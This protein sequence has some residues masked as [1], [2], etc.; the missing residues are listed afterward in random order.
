LIDNG[1]EIA[2]YL[3][4]FFKFTHYKLTNILR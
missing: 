1:E 2:V 3:D 4:V